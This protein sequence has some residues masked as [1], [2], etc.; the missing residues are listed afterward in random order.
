MVFLAGEVVVDYSLR[1]KKEL[2][3]ERLWIT[4]FAN[5]VPCYIASRRVIQEGGYEVESSMYSYNRPSRFSEVVEDLIVAAV[6][7]L[8]PESYKPKTVNTNKLCPIGWHVPT[9]DEWKS[10]E[11]YLGGIDIA[12]G[13]LKEAGTTHWIS[14]NTGATNDSDFSALPAGRG[15][16][17]FGDFKMMG[18]N[19]TFW[20]AT[21]GDYLGTLIAYSMG[22]S[23][24]ENK[25]Y[26]AEMSFPRYGFSVRCIKN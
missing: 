15:D 19:T 10:L 2:V 22:L 21:E 8:L 25:V 18:T 11:T 24:L 16:Y 4:A 9:I 14:P 1:L 7:D 23:N 5:D 13:K 3:A 12:G 20:S 26:S 17:S 6:Y